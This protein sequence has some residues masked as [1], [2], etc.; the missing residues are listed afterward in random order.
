MSGYEDEANLPDLEEAVANGLVRCRRELMAMIEDA[1]AAR[2]YL[3]QNIAESHTEVAMTMN[4]Y[5]DALTAGC[6]A[7]STKLGRIAEAVCAL[8]NWT[9]EE[10]LSCIGDYRNF[11][12]RTK[13]ADLR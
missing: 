2:Y 1:E 6:L 9:P 7:M 4:A 8:D 12:F 13:G 11:D 3:G 10:L 5:I